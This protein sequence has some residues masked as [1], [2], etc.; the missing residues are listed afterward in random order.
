MFKLHLTRMSK[1]QYAGYVPNKPVTLKQ[2]KGHRPWHTLLD[3]KYGYYYAKFEK[4]CLNSV[5]ENANIKLFVRSGNMV[6]CQKCCQTHYS[7]RHKDLECDLSTLC[8]SIVKGIT[9]ILRSETEV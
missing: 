3:P 6:L 5:W 2:G 4:P 7:V 1:T 8:L 9:D